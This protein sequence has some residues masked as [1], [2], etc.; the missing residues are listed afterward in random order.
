VAPVR[1]YHHIM[2]TIGVDEAGRGPILGPMVMAA[3][4]LTPRRAAALTR[5]GVC[6]SK[7]FGAGPQAHA[8]RAALAERILAAAEAFQ[9]VVV[10]VGEIDRHV[11]FG[12]LNRLEQRHADQMLRLL[13]AA[14][15]IVADGRNLFS[16]LRARWPQLEAR[17]EGETV[18]ASV[19]AASILAKVRRDQLWLRI[20]AR[21]RRDFGDIDGLGYVNPATKRFLREYIARHR[22]LPPEARRTWPWHFARDL[23]PPG[24]DVLRD[25]C[26]QQLALQLV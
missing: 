7:A 22:A 19:A 15:R 11:R 13:P 25:V 24:F 26:E 20:E 4:A 16:P 1:R 5:A 14:D 17:N 10:D 3:V 23:L 6:D 2:L 18:H 21:Y 12:E 8:E 9:I